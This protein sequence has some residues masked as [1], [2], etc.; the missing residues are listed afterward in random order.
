MNRKKNEKWYIR[1]RFEN[2]FIPNLLGCWIWQGAPAGAIRPG[3]FRGVFKID[4]KPHTAPR[5]SMWLYKDFDLSNPFMILHK[6]N[7]TMCVNPEHLYLG[8]GSDNTNDS[9]LAGT[10]ARMGGRPRKA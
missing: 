10:H 3:G 1:R 8:T 7:N 4:G 9:V 2:K 6:C 5:V